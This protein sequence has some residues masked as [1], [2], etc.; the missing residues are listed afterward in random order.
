MRRMQKDKSSPGSAIPFILSSFP[1][2]TLRHSRTRENP[3]FHSRILSTLFILSNVFF[4]ASSTGGCQRRQ[5]AVRDGGVNDWSVPIL[6]VA[7]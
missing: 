7:P 3:F 2:S 4:S 5:A 1:A 6:S